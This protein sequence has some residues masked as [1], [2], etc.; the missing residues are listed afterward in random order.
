LF[1]QS[2]KAFASLGRI[3]EY[4]TDS[5]SHTIGANKAINGI[6]GILKYIYIINYNYYN[7]S[8]YNNI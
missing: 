2:I 7:D 6:E 8:G 3:N 5:E 1:G 4:V